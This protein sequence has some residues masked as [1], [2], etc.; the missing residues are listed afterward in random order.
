[1][2]ILR[3]AAAAALA[4][5]NEL[6]H[7]NIGQQCVVEKIVLQIQIGWLCRQC[8]MRPTETGDS[9]STERRWRSNR[10]LT[11]AAAAMVVVV[12]VVVCQNGTSCLKSIWSGSGRNSIA[13]TAALKRRYWWRSC[14]QEE[15]ATTTITSIRR[16]KVVVVSR[17]HRCG[18]IPEVFV[19]CWGSSW[20]WQTT[21][22]LMLLQRCSYSLIHV[23]KR[24]EAARRMISVQLKIGFRAPQWSQFL[25]FAFG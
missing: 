19:I 11:A 25:P 17:L 14:G 21:F 22:L 5:R 10:S 9:R 20:F 16:K 4:L 15:I 3:D 7:I 13:T 2:T 1:M 12:A 23:L 24:T 18:T 8:V 6:I